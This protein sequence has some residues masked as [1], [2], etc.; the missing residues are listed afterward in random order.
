MTALCPACRQIIQ[1]P[2]APLGAPL[3]PDIAEDRRESFRA[4][5]GLCAAVGTHMGSFHADAIQ[6]ASLAMSSMLSYQLMAS[7]ESTDPEFQY[8]L[9]Q[10]RAEV[11]GVLRGLLDGHLI[12]PAPEGPAKQ[13]RG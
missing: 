11:A 12:G 4:W 13:A 8:W 7:V 6:A 10:L 3:P 5:A 9:G 1:A 2:A